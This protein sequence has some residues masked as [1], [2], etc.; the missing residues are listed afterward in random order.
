MQIRYCQIAATRTSRS[1]FPFPAGAQGLL[2]PQRRGPGRI[3][4]LLSRGT[5][6]K[7]NDF[8]VIP[9]KRRRGLGSWLVGAV[10]EVTDGLGIERIDLSVRRD[11]PGALRFWESQ[12]FMI[13]HHELT[14]FRDPHRRV[15]FR[16]ALSSD[17]AEEA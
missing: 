4:L 9:A 17:F 11:N 7:I 10:T 15:G 12:G 13:G 3:C 2:V 5:R 1:G 16:G 14:Q 6:A 8:Y